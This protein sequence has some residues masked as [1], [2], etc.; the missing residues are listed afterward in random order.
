MDPAHLSAGVGTP[1]KRYEY[2]PASCLCPSPGPSLLA[3]VRPELFLGGFSQLE[4][5]QDFLGVKS[6]PSELLVPSYPDGA[7]FGGPLPSFRSGK[8][9][10]LSSYSISPGRHSNG[11]LL[12]NVLIYVCLEIDHTMRFTPESMVRSFGQSLVRTPSTGSPGS[13]GHL[14]PR[15]HALKRPLLS[16]HTPTNLSGFS[17]RPVSA[18]V[19][20]IQLSH[21]ISESCVCCFRFVAIYTL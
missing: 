10:S 12:W 20:P 3:P 18:H 4:T 16:P 5:G 15:G 8:K 13:V 14:T 21:P 7:C 6:S 11:I 19:F 9:R 17:Q 1:R 2:G